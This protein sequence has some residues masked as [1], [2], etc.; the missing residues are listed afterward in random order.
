MKAVQNKIFF[1][2]TRLP[3][4]KFRIF[5]AQTSKF[6]GWLCKRNAYI[7]V[8]DPGDAYLRRVNQRKQA[9]ADVACFL[10]FGPNIQTVLARNI[11][12]P[13]T[14]NMCAAGFGCVDQVFEVVVSDVRCEA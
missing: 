2:K 7:K 9:A 5:F 11:C 14:K 13:R 4:P 3:R 10:E 6:G 1:P 8:L 12:R